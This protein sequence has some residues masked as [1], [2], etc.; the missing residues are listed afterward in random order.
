M[1]VYRTSDGDTLDW[2]CWR[3]YGRSSGTVEAVLEANP[4]LA[5]CGP[6]YA[7]GLEIVLPDLPL[8]PK[9]NIVRLWE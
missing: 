6:V 7:A 2:I 1:Q 8:A 4:K 3:K 5:A 9:Q